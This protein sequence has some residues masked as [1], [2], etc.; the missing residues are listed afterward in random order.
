MSM[1]IWFKKSIYLSCGLSILLSAAAGATTPDQI[2]AQLT[3]Q[4]PSPL[5]KIG[6][7]F[8]H[9]APLLTLYKLRGYRPIWV[10]ADGKLTPMAVK[11]R[12]VLKTAHLHG[13]NVADYWDATLEGYSTSPKLASFSITL[14]LMMSEALLRYVDH[15][16]NGRLDPRQVDSDIKVDRKAFKDFE[17]LK[18]TL[19]AAESK[20]ASAEELRA[21]LDKFAPNGANYA[22]LKQLLAYF[23]SIDD[24]K[25]WS[26]IKVPSSKFMMG[27]KG[28]QVVQLRLRLLSLGYHLSN[29]E[30][31][32][33]DSEVDAAVRKFQE[34]NN[35]TSDGVVG[36]Q[37][38]R[39]MNV[40]V[41]ERI[42]QIEAN[43]ERLRWLPSEMPTRYVYVNIAAAEFR[44][45]DNYKRVMKFQAISGREHW[46]T[47]MLFNDRVTYV[48]LNPEWVVPDD[49]AKT[50]IPTIKENPNYLSQKGFS[51]RKWVKGSLVDVSAGERANIDWDRFVG[52]YVLVQ[53]A[54]TDNALGVV[55]FPLRNEYSIY[56]HYTDNKNLF[57]DT[58]RQLSAG[59]VRLEDPFQFAEYILAGNTK[60]ISPLGNSWTQQEMKKL[61][62]A[63]ES[64]RPDPRYQKM[65]I[66]LIT[67]VPVF[68]TYYTVDRTDDAELR[69]LPDV[70]GQ[71][72]RIVNMIKVK[73]SGELF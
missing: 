71:D 44:L 37:V 14:E 72:K 23:R 34:S 29:F 30:S 8:L 43:M 17:V 24:D 20:S 58:S 60:S 10:T 36:P 3:R 51:V 21:M 49:I 2:E 65:R 61:V 35:L 22:D 52:R 69:F 6:D 64:Q 7:Y 57:K 15:L 1:K 66:P 42:M 50:K 68:L 13:L 26:E 46:R 32:V 27:F 12:A 33:F 28:P 39:F 47:P 59:C 4:S 40:P 67:P 31:S 53:E 70:Y 25:E 56:L 45:Y 16:Q 62:P 41:N 54:R 55:K 48:E 38:L 11:L 73:S 5:F 9:Q 19:D 18:K 63:D